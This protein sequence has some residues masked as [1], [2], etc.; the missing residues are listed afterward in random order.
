MAQS[1]A[2]FAECATA[3][4]TQAEAARALGI[5]PY[6]VSRFARKHGLIFARKPARREV[7][8]RCAQQGMTRAEAAEA[9]GVTKQAAYMAARRYGF[10]FRRP[11]PGP[12]VRLPDMGRGALLTYRKIRKAGVSR[13]EALRALGREESH[14]R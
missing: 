5:E 9:L 13:E 3:G 11:S 6:L 4:M 2:D 1:P 12:T 14:A 10:E 8:A 7:W